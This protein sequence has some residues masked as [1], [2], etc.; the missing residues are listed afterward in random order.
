MQRILSL[1]K[2][3]DS[4]P[5]SFNDTAKVTRSTIPAANFPARLEVPVI[6]QGKASQRCGVTG[7]A[8]TTLGGG[9]AASVALIPARKRGRPV[10]KKDSEPRKK[11]GTEA[12]TSPF[13]IDAVTPSHE[14]VSDY[15]YVHEST[16]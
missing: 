3:A 16:I 6:G 7:N 5:N 9:T 15:S 11:R 14:I 8:G 13:I 2:V 12:Q 10:G 1:Q 4:M